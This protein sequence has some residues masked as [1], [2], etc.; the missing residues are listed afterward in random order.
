VPGVRIVLYGLDGRVA[1]VATTTAQ[2]EYRIPLPAGTYR[3]VIG[4]LR[5]GESV[6]NL[7]PTVTLQ[8]GIETRLDLR[9]DTGI[10]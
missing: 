4:N 5:P 8:P 6:K 2:G 3:I 10:R 9:V 7:P 1:G